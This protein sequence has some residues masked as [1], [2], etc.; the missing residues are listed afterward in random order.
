V[1]AKLDYAQ[2]L[3]S[4]SVDAFDTFSEQADF[5]AGQQ[6]NT[7][8]FNYYLDNMVPLDPDP[9]KKQPARFKA[10]AAITELFETAETNNL[11]GISGTKWSAYNAVTEY[12]DHHKNTRGGA[13]GRL[14]SIWFGAGARMKEKALEFALK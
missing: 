4:L 10:R 14:N 9:D 11:P 1:E 8:W 12:V 5:M 13:D 7:E 6:A 2:R 3:L